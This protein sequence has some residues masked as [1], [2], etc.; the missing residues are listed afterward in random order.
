VREAAAQA[1]APAPADAAVSAFFGALIEAAREVQSHTL[2]GPPAGAAPADLERSLRP[3]LARISERIAWLLVRLPAPL[4]AVE[5]ERALA[6]LEDTAVSAATRD[7]IA[8]ALLA[9]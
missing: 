8:R 4:D 3:A 9:L 2:A 5:V 6:P 7:R 1:G